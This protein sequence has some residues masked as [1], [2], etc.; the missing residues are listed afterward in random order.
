[1]L[2]KFIDKFFGIPFF[3]HYARWL[4]TLGI[5]YEPIKT[6]LDPKP[7]D[8]VLD[9]A[10]GVGT[11]TKIVDD[12]KYLG[13]DLNE[14][15]I[16]T[17]NKEWK[18]DKRNFVVQDVLTIDQKYPKNSF[19]KGMMLGLIHHLPEE[20]ALKLLKKSSE[21][22]TERLV[23][24]DNFYSKWHLINN[25]VCHLD[26]G[27]FV[28]TV[29]HERM[30][31]SQYFEIEKERRYYVNSRLAHYVVFQLKPKPQLN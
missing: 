15:Y 21:I 16:E 18:T 17:A 1:M 22:L 2:S 8:S 4:F 23:V 7:E 31:L 11:Y 14:E 3:Y 9:I 10:C 20:D 12:A 6:F 19:N 28:R 13:I 26:R 27:K 25:L 24:M 5:R 30:I 29:E